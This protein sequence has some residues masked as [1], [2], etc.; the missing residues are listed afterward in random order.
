MHMSSRH[1]FIPVLLLFLVACGN[2]V[3]KK[4]FDLGV[5]KL[6][7]PA[8]WTKFQERGIDTYVGGI[9]NGRDTLHY[10]YG[11][12]NEDVSEFSDEKMRYA[13]DVINGYRANIGLS[14][15]PGHVAVMIVNVNQGMQFI[16]DGYNLSQPDVAL[17]IF[18]SVVFKGSDVSKNRNTPIDSFNVHASASGKS[19]FRTNCASCHSLHKELTGPALNERMAVR[20]NQWLYKFLADRASVSADTGQVMLKKQY[21]F[22]CPDFSAM[23]EEECRALIDYIRA[24]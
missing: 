15:A 1:I 18:R 8:D 19:L 12:Y 4:T 16:M 23:S 9:T 5:F 13:A 14:E 17:D 2:K 20:D 24:R 21:G 7:V 6:T 11:L 3:E 22:E 10:G